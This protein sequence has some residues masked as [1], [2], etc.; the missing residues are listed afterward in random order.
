MYFPNRG[1]QS[2]NMCTQ[3]LQQSE[4]TYDKDTTSISNYTQIKVSE[5]S[6]SYTVFDV[7]TWVSNYI[8]P[9]TKFR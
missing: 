9:K 3:K 5:L 6:F 4:S 7:R 2:T 1:D 8:P